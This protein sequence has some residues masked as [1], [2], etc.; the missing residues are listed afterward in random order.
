[1]ATKG[2]MM[3][4][5]QPPL[6]TAQTAGQPQVGVDPDEQTY[7]ML[8]AGLRTHIFGKGE[9]GIVKAIT[10]AD[11]IGRVV[12]EVVFALVK[13]AATQ[14]SKANRDLDLDIL[15][16]VATEVIDDI[17]ELMAGHGVEI[18]EKDREFALMYAQQLY[19][20]SS[21]P[22]DDDREAAKSLL[23]DLK[24]DG[25]VDQAVSYVQ[26]RGAEEG[27][28]PFGVEGDVGRPG[29]MGGGQ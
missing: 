10:N 17:T 20:E 7:T 5:G 25:S 26:Q 3:G 6:D 12:G 11:Q 2:M 4:G 15:M 9:A 13:E 23:R 8:V 22:T 28:D 1:M 24:Q 16:G 18:S 29:M 19:V 21:D 14:A 27:V